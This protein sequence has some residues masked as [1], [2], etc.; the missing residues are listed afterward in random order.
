[1]LNVLARQRE[2]RS[3]VTILNTPQA[4][5]LRIEPTADCSRYDSLR[6]AI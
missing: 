1:V 4:L 2:P 6:R 5:R 3:P